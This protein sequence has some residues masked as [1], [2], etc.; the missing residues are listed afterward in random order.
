ML[1][2]AVS[3]LVV[4]QSS[5]EIPEGLMNNP[6]YFTSIKSATSSMVYKYNS[7]HNAPHPEFCWLLQDFKKVKMKK[8]SCWLV[9]I[10]VVLKRLELNVSRKWLTTQREVGFCGVW[11]IFWTVMWLQFQGVWNENFIIVN[12][13]I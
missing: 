5:S 6:V 12:V 9:L 3:V 7:I 11:W 2:S 13:H 8:F 10:S 4:A 1:L